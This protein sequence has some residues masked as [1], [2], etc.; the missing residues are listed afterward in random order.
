[1]EQGNY[2]TEKEGHIHDSITDY[3]YHLMTYLFNNSFEF[4]QIPRKLTISLQIIDHLGGSYIKHAFNYDQSCFKL[5]KYDSIGDF[6]Y[7]LDFVYNDYPKL[8]NGSVFDYC[9]KIEIQIKEE[10]QFTNKLLVLRFLKDSSPE[11]IDCEFEE[12]NINSNETS[13]YKKRIHFKEERFL[14]DE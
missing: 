1:M 6:E 9:T 13:S 8:S 4:F 14:K 2:Q 7:L 10:D 5:K 11:Y 12:R 3:V